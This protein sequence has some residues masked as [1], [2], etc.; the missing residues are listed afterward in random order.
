[1]SSLTTYGEIDDFLEHYGV[2]GMKWGVRK[3][4]LSEYNSRRKARYEAFQKIPLLSMTV[5]AKNGKDVELVQNPK[6]PITAT[7]ASLSDKR[8]AAATNFKTFRLKVDGQTVG[9]ASFNWESKDRLKLEWIGVDA[10]QRGKGYASTVFD[11]AIAYAKAN[12]A[13]ELLLEVPGNAPDARHIY[14]KRGFIAGKDVSPKGDIWGGLTEMSLSLLEPE[15]VKHGDVTTEEEEFELALIRTFQPLIEED[16]ADA[17][18]DEFLEHY[19]VK[20]MKW[21]VRRSSSSGTSGR[22]NKT[23]SRPTVKS[24]SDDELRRRINRIQMERA[25]NT[26]TEQQTASGKAKA[27]EFG[28]MLLKDIVVSS[29]KEIGKEIFKQILKDQIKKRTGLDIGKKKK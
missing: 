10:D 5:K 14:E 16:A 11:A 29:A 7:I 13:K 17:E 28:K 22:T 15:K 2:K 19:G 26:L 3:A 12:G 1:M 20:G 6:H 24:M 8:Y 27:Q 23:P 4:R 21:G 18:V 25:Y 9:D